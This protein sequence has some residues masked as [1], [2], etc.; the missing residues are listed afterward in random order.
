MIVELAKI[1]PE[2]AKELQGTYIDKSRKFNPIQ[3]E[4][5]WYVSMEESKFIDNFEIV[6]LTLIQDDK[7]TN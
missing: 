2:Q 6:K 5:N 7:E 3:I 1:T 4:N